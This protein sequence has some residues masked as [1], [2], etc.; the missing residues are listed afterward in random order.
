M[1][2]LEELSCAAARK[3]PT[4]PAW[5]WFSHSDDDWRDGRIVEGKGEGRLCWLHECT[6]ACAEIMVRVLWPASVS[7]EQS[8][9]REGELYAEASAGM[10]RVAVH[11]DPMQ[12]FRTA[13]LRAVVAL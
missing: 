6:E 11:N 13:V 9:G 2:E 12:A 10:A 8:I 1:S 5:P 4:N 7:I 3:L